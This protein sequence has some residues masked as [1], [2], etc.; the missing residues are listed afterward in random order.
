[1]SGL[2][3]RASSSASVRS[4]FESFCEMSFTRLGFATVTS[5]PRSLSSWLIQRE[6]VPTSMTTCARGRVKKTRIAARVVFTGFGRSTFP[7]ASKMN[8]SLCL[9]PSTRPQRF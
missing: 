7:V 2:P 6:C 8:N 9:S 3:S 1:M 4:S 5:C